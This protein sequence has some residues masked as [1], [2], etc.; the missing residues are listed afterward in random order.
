MLRIC[1]MIL[2]ILGMKDS[3]DWSGLMATL[4]IFWCWRYWCHTAK[5]LPYFQQREKM[6]QA[7]HPGIFHRKSQATHCFRCSEKPKTVGTIY[8]SPY[9]KWWWNICSCM[10]YELM[11][12]D[13]EKNIRVFCV[14]DQIITH[15]TKSHI[16]PTPSHP[17]AIGGTQEA[18]WSQSQGGYGLGCWFGILRVPLS[19]NP[20]H[21][22]ILGIQTGPQANK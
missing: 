5:R 22:G 9:I 15:P 14:S 3:N 13:V 10:W 16:I 4:W 12:W 7:W 20:F 19:N 1:S 8:R 18:P 21:R 11:W 6:W 17:I 2:L